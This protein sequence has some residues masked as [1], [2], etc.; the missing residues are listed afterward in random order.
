MKQKVHGTKAAGPKDRPMRAIL[1][2][3]AAWT[4]TQ[5]SGVAVV[6]E[7]PNGWNLAG[8]AASY[9]AFCR[10]DDPGLQ[11]ELRPVVC[12]ADVAKLI[13]AACGVCGSSI[14]LVAV[15]MPLARTPIRSRRAADRV[16]S[17]VYGARQ[18]GTHTPNALRPGPVG[19]RLRD[20]LAELGYPLLTT[21]LAPRGTIEVYPHPALVELAG[22]PK[23]LPYKVSKIRKYWPEATPSERRERLIR[24]WQS[25]VGLLD[26]VIT[27][28]HAMLPLPPAGVPA[29]ALKAFEDKLD[30]IICAWVGICALDGRAQPYGDAESAIWIPLAP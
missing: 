6:V 21:A 5:P 20:G 14:D 1:G 16:V 12:E 17:T 11:P 22:A 28:V 4:L 19:E 2:I 10:L 8:T 18:C 3:D 25:I 23:R 15:D 24:E 7:S 26:N 29:I 9:H 13:A 30:A 27:G